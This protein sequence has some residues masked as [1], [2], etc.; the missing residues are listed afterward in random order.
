[1]CLDNIFQLKQKFTGI[2]YTK[3]IVYVLGSET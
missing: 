1:M 2:I 3:V